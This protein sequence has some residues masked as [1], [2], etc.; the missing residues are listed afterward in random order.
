MIMRNLTHEACHAVLGVALVC[1]LA[2]PA[3]AQ[4]PPD[5]TV[6][7][8]TVRYSETGFELV[9]TDSLVSVLPP[10]DELP[11]EIGSL[12]GFWF[13]LQDADGVTLYRRVIGDP[14][15]LVFE[16]PALDNG[17]EAA[18]ISARRVPSDRKRSSRVRRPDATEARAVALNETGAI[19]VEPLQ[20]RA[21]SDSELLAAP[22]RSE[23]VPAERFFSLLIPLAAAGDELVLFSSPIDVGAQAGAA[24]EVARFELL[25]A[26]P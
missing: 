13:E 6:D 2:I 10:S 11:G 4:D 23:A 17:M 24:T 8:V 18:R 12:G 14:V 15:R 22:E 21:S 26:Q 9:S 16:G 7:R 19:G 25:A 1:L 5:P 20:G 3:I